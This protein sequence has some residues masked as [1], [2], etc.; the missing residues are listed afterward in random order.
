VNTRNQKWKGVLFDFDY[1]LADS[2]AGAVACVNHA[3]EQMGLPL[4]P[5]EQIH[6]TIGMSLPVAFRDLTG[7]GSSHR[8]EAFERLFMER[9][10]QV[11]AARTMLFPTTGPTLKTL[12]D[13]GLKL[14]IVSTKTRHRIVSILQRE[15]LAGHFEVIIGGGEVSIHKPDPSGLLLAAEQLGCAVSEVVYVGDSVIDA[16]A[17]QRGEVSFVAVLSGVTPR[18]AFKDYASLAVIETLNELPMVLAR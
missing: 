17:A 15:G 5:P 1:T 16:E 4:V 10:D 6:R 13:Q 14:G 12:E 9:A 7:E 8:A 18:T 3:L 11:M 2:S